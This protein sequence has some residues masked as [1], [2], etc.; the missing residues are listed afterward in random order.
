MLYYVKNNK[1][2]SLRSQIALKRNYSHP[3]SRAHNSDR[4]NANGSRSEI[5]MKIS[6]FK[7]MLTK[8]LYI[9][10]KTSPLPSAA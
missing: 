4:V 8:F 5:T 6:A 2:E 1:K 9:Y 3:C 10:K 7:R